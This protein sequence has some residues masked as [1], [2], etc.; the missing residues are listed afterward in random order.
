MDV[1][2]ILDPYVVVSYCTSY[3]TKFDKTITRELKTIII[4]CSENENQTNIHIQKLR[5]TFLN[6]QQM[7]T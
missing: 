2:F 3:L 7:S 6:V 4:N 1:Q 5:N